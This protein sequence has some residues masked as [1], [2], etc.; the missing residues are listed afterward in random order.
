MASNAATAPARLGAVRPNIEASGP[1]KQEAMSK[2]NSTTTAP[3]KNRFVPQPKAPGH[4]VAL[5]H[6]NAL[7]IWPK[8]TALKAAPDAASSA[9]PAGKTC[10]G[11]QPTATKAARKASI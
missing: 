1:D 8:P 5:R 7:A 4:L 6:A 2:R 10:P 9:G 11:R 3:N